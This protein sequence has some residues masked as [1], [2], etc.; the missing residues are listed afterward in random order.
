[1]DTLPNWTRRLEGI[2][3]KTTGVRI[4]VMVRAW[5]PLSDQC[6]PTSWAARRIGGRV[7]QK[8]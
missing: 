2:G 8:D 5:G 4:R 3:E 6:L 7:R 1:M